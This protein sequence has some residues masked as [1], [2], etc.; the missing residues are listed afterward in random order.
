MKTVFRISNTLLILV[1][2]VSFSLAYQP[3]RAQS[4]PAARYDEYVPGQVIVKFETGANARQYNTKA[5]ALSSSVSANLLEV[6]PAG[7]ALLAVSP[8]EDVRALAT[9]LAAQPG[10][11]SAEPNYIY[12]LSLPALDEAQ[13]QPA[14]TVER[15]TGQ[16]EKIDVPVPALKALTL[17]K[18]SVYPNDPNLW[19]NLGW[20]MVGA[21]IV[22]SNNT[23]SKTVC[24]IDTGVDYKHPDLAGRIIRGHDYVNE[25]NDPMDDHGHGT[26]VA[27]LISAKKGNGLG[28]AGVSTGKVLAMKAFS[29]QGVGTSFEIDKAIQACANRSDVSVILLGFNGVYSAMMRDVIDQAVNVHGK[30]LVVAAGDDFTDTPTYPA[31]LSLEFPNRVLSVGATGH[32][33]VDDSYDGIISNYECLANYSNYGNWVDIL[34]PGTRI[35]ST[36][37]WDRPF[38]MHLQ[39]AAYLRYD[40][41]SGTAASAAYVAA[42]AAR[43][44]GYKPGFTNE[45]VA[46]WMKATGR[47]A[48]DELGVMDCRPDGFGNGLIPN[49]AASLE[50][51]ALQATAQ[52]ANTGLP[53]YGAKILAYKNGLLVGSGQITTQVNK[54]IAPYPGYS[55]FTNYTEIINLPASLSLEN[56]YTLKLSKAGYTQTPA[57]AFVNELTG[58]E[59]SKVDPGY[60]GWGGAA[61][62]PPKNANFTAVAQPRGYYEYDL[63]TFL[64]KIPKPIDDHQPA[65][66]IVSANQ[67]M[68][69][70]FVEDDPTGTLGFFPFARQVYELSLSSEG[71]DATVV[72][73]RPGNAR[74]PYYTGDYTFVV[75]AGLG[76]DSGQIG[77][78]SNQTFFLWK[79]GLIKA[80][81][82]PTC[83]G[84]WWKAVTL[85]SGLSGSAAILIEDQCGTGSY[86]P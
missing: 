74:L 57:A 67:G 30:L 9:S 24:L 77:D 72:R 2:L 69:Y 29:S 79:D 60:W 18:S 37:P 15:V 46:A 86:I 1:L 6:S 33:W 68:D 65:P 44:W 49:V 52:D 26:W 40:Y 11:A 82:Q 34:A 50:R 45:Q 21:D 25:D 51:G 76:A 64:P 53:L 39:E 10:V 47:R 85:R 48:D 22:S 3:A 41:S 19:D 84:D 14:E 4:Q 73:A 20:R 81:M 71:W 42:T 62:A 56:D 59:K 61:V 36:L 83:S 13:K 63:V 17:N 66:F 31:A 5:N 7:V 43:I 16:G 58:S 35:Y 78:D 80:R 54:Y 55:Y 32:E 8:D 12:R 28:I 75:V 23:P 38:M 70:G 27:G